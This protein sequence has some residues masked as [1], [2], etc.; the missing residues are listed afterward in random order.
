MARWDSNPQSQD[1][2]CR[3][4]TPQIARILGP[5]KN[6]LVRRT[7]EAE[8]MCLEPQRTSV[9]FRYGNCNLTLN[10]T[11]IFRFL[12]S[13]LAYVTIHV[14]SFFMNSESSIPFSCD[15]VKG[16]NIRGGCANNVYS[17]LVTYMQIRP[18]SNLSNIFSKAL[19]FAIFLSVTE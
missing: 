8:I 18:A 3:K 5:A 2:S 7:K 10:L 1:S 9:L 14:K 19:S 13:A 17:D 12:C 6:R 11:E 4:T 16:V 15:N